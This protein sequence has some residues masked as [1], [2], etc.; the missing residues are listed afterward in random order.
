M[1]ERNCIS[2]SDYRQ[3]CDPGACEKAMELRC[4]SDI[5]SLYSFQNELHICFC[6]EQADATV[7]LD[8]GITDLGL[9][10]SQPLFIHSLRSLSPLVLIVVDI[11]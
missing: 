4:I 7:V 8:L 3:V 6:S 11:A 9:T 10:C 1:I 2:K 5:L